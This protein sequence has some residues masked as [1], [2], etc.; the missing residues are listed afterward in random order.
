MSAAPGRLRLFV[1]IV[2]LIAGAL[3]SFWW[4]ETMQ[5]DQEQAAT[6]PPKGEPDYTVE[7]FNLVRMAKNG[8]ARYN[9]SG[10]KLVHYPDTDVF[11]IE[12]PVLYNVGADRITMML[13]AE[14]ALVE[15]K[16]NRVHLHRQVQAERA[17][18]RNNEGFHLASEYLLLLP[19][20]DIIQTD[21]RVDIVSGK[22]RV[23]GVGMVANNATREFRLLNDVHARFAPR[24]Q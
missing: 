9:I 15:H 23:S 13:R 11:E 10:A 8:H 2:L 7:K 18:N 5:R 1:I 12:R 14:R 16:T 6:V 4:A 17:A 24:P 3:G 19:D 22:S 20:E 21:K